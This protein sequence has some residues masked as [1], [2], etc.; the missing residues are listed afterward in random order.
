MTAEEELEVLHALRY[1]MLDKIYRVS[2][3]IRA[4]RNTREMQVAGY[5]FLTLATDL[6]ERAKKLHQSSGPTQ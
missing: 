3:F 4:A 5:S 1:E 2:H 6:Y